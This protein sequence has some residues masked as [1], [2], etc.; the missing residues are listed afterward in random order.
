MRGGGAAVARGGGFQDLRCRPLGLR[1]ADGP[2]G[3]FSSDV[4]ECSTRSASVSVS[5]Q[6]PK[7]NCPF[8]EVIGLT[9]SSVLVTGDTRAAKGHQVTHGGLA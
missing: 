9:L 5:S 6:P 7:D 8:A 2:E 4:R 3:T 1:A